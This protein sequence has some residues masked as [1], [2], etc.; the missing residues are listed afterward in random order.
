MQVASAPTS[1]LS[2]LARTASYRCSCNGGGKSLASPRAGSLAPWRIALCSP[3]GSPWSR[4]ICHYACHPERCDR[5]AKS[6]RRGGGLPR[7][8]QSAMKGASL[9]IGSTDT[10]ASSL[11]LRG[12][13]TSE[14]FALGREKSSATARVPQSIIPLTQARLRKTDTRARAGALYCVVESRIAIESIDVLSLSTRRLI[15]ERPNNV[16]FRT[17]HLSDSI[18]NLGKMPPR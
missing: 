15:V 14:R 2:A 5:G 17:S 4:A 13:H 8:R 7:A 6:V 3:C 12:A 9:F 10:T 1:V 11:G 16:T 18:G